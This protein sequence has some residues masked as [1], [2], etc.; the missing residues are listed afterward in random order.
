MNSKLSPEQVQWHR[1]YYLKFTVDDSIVD[2]ILKYESLLTQDAWRGNC[3]VGKG[4]LPI[5]AKCFDKLLDLNLPDFKVVQV[6]EKFGRLVIYTSRLPTEHASIL[7]LIIN[8]AEAEACKTCE[9]C[10]APHYEIRGNGWL[11]NYCD[12]CEN[13][14]NKARAKYN[15]LEA[16]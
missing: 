12:T 3:H 14:R 11:K 6:K 4:W 1:D 16:L 2:F 13:D 7:D 5:V 15:D 10:G 8:I 9:N